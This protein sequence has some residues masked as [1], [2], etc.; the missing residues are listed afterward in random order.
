MY[1][2]GGP[3]ELPSSELVGMG[4]EKWKQGLLCSN[5]FNGLS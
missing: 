5:I 4:Q 3:A 1:N 2:K